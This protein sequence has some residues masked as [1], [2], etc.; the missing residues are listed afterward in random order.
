LTAAALVVAGSCGFDTTAVALN[1]CDSHARTGR[2]GRFLNYDAVREI[3]QELASFPVIK[4]SFRL[5]P[6]SY[7]LAVDEY[8]V[9]FSEEYRRI[10]DRDGEQD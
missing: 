10:V 8:R 7:R 1:I 2:D 9:W 5:D 3:E 6:M 4:G